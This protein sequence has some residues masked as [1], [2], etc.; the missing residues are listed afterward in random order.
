MKHNDRTTE[1]DGDGGQE[2]LLV[3]ILPRTDLSGNNAQVM[4]QTSTV[5]SV[6]LVHVEEDVA[7]SFPPLS[8]VLL[9]GLSHVAVVIA[10]PHSL[11]TTAHIANVV[12]CS[13]VR[14]KNN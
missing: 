2:V 11:P 13:T 4:Q 10:S 6:L 1:S 9:P 3:L 7:S 5:R 8:N 12:P 14:T